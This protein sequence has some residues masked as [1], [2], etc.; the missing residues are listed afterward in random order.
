M[1][2]KKAKP[3][4]EEAATSEPVVP[5]SVQDQV[6]GRLDDFLK[7]AASARTK[8]LTLGG[9]EYAEDLSKTLMNHANAI[10][11]VYKNIQKAVKQK[12]SSKHFQTFLQQMDDK[13][14]LSAKYKA[15]SKNSVWYFLF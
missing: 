3:A 7:S 10:E 4:K 9:L 12:L 8:S 14:V 5:A 6:L 11:A 15:R 1:A 2:K 13:D